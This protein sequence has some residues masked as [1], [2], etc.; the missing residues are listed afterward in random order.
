MSMFEV[1]VLGLTQGLTEFIPVS[2]SGHLILLEHFF[3]GR[4]D[5]LFVQALDIG[6]TLALIIYFWP[7]IMAIIR[8]IF[9]E[10]DYRLA[11]NV[12]IT[13]VPAGLIGLALSSVIEK[14]SVLV[15]PFLVAAMLGL[16]GIVMIVVDKLPHLSKTSSGQRLTPGRALIIGIAQAFALIPGVSRSGS[17]I[18][19]SRFMGLNPAKAAEYSFLVAIPILLGLIAKLLIGSSDRAYLL[20]HL[21]PV[22]IGNVAAFVSGIIAIRFMLN[23]LSRHGLAVFGWYRVA[24]SLIVLGLLLLQ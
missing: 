13:S 10:K 2:S 20:S 16:V 4:S 9:V 1:I 24:A 17:T 3:T 19:A 5:H 12:I 14:S 8:Q 15:N 11:R 23:Y 21:E 7:R 6:T 22:I 18:V